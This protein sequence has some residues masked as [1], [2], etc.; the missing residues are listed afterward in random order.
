P[1]SVGSY[2]AARLPPGHCAAAAAACAEASTNGCASPAVPGYPGAQNT[3]VVVSAAKRE[4]IR[5]GY[6]CNA[7][8]A[9][10]G[11]WGLSRENM[12]L[13]GPPVAVRWFLRTLSLRHWIVGVFMLTTAAGVF[14]ALRVAD[15]SAIES[16]VVA[17]DPLARATQAFQRLFPEGTQA[18]LML[19]A[20]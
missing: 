13:P 19:E 12:N 16:L 17:S 2:T 15:D 4:P 9:S 10:C 8:C 6:H 18:L 1:S 7:R 3:S 5:I 11:R 20:D 14:G